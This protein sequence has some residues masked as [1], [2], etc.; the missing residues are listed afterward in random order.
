[1]KTYKLFLI[2]MLVFSLSSCTAEHIEV[3]NCVN[4]D[5]DGF[6]MGL[7]HGVIAPVTFFISLF[8]ESVEIYSINNNGGWYNFGFVI[9]AGILLGS[10]SRSKN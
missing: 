9:G 3:V 1:M 5:P 6:L 7:W 10:S 4:G 2:V 8:D